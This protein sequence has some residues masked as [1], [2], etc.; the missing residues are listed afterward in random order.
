MHVTCVCTCAQVDPRVSRGRG[1]PALSV[2]PAAAELRASV[3]LSAQASTQALKSELCRQR[4]IKKTSVRAVR[5]M[6]QLWR[7]LR[8]LKCMFGVSKCTEKPLRD[9][10]NTAKVDT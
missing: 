10:K 5:H 9:L 3:G 8:R 2:K 6:K 1:R 7:R 4:H